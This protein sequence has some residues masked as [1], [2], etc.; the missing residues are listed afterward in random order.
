MQQQQMMMMSGPYETETGFALTPNGAIGFAQEI[1]NKLAVANAVTQATAAQVK[2]LAAT[3]APEQKATGGVQSNRDA[4]ARMQI[5][6]E[7][8]VDNNNKE[9]PMENRRMSL[10]Q[11]H[12]DDLEDN[13]FDSGNE[14]EEHHQEMHH[15]ASLF[16]PASGFHGVETGID[17]LSR[18]AF[19]IHHNPDVFSM[20]NHKNARVMA[21]KL[22][23]Q[24][25]IYRVFRQKLNAIHGTTGKSH[26]RG[27]GEGLAPSINVFRSYDQT[28]NASGVSKEVK[29]EFSGHVKNLMQLWDDFMQGMPESYKQFAELNPKMNFWKAVNE[30]NEKAMKAADFRTF[31][32]MGSKMKILEDIYKKY[33]A[34]IVFIEKN[35][36]P[37]IMPST[38]EARQMFSK[39]VMEKVDEIRQRYHEG[40]GKE[41]RKKRR[42]EKKQKKM[43]ASTPHHQDPH[44][45]KHDEKVLEAA[46]GMAKDAHK[47]L[48]NTTIAVANAAKKENSPKNKEG[49]MAPRGSAAPATPKPNNTAPKPAGT[50]Q[51]AMQ[52]PTTVKK[53]ATPFGGSSNNN[54]HDF[55]TCEQ[56]IPVP[57]TH[58]PYHYPSSVPATATGG[59]LG[60]TSKKAAKRAAKKMQMQQAM[61]PMAWQPVPVTGAP[62]V[63]YGYAPMTGGP[64]PYGYAP[65]MCQ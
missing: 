5:T 43:A 63:P 47:A 13:A 6:C 49:S 27:K 64:V 19:D 20:E 39:A 2:T 58:A 41:R 28:K 9:K 40:E 60:F 62:A 36:L 42:Q 21:K 45:S 25:Q 33:A 34:I 24:W 16:E 57:I 52:T 11:Q 65:V 48:V 32:R 8:I 53:R 4:Y 22:A 55:C 14:D 29:D 51:V 38:E 44:H 30:M 61:V 54:N 50:M 12:D 31:K 26:R 56:P 1:E 17:A 23:K 7:S 10:Y 59:P 37:R 46:I 15:L 3:P 35:H 18:I